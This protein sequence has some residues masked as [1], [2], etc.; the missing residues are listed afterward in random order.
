MSTDQLLI[1]AMALPVAER[2]ELAQALWE[3]IDAGLADT[4]ERAAIREAIQRDGELSSGDVAGLSHDEVMKAA[5]QA[6]KC[7]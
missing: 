1:D 5:R 3:S 6:L 7:D 2:V 4:D